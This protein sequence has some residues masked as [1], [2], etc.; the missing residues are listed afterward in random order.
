MILYIFDM[1]VV[2]KYIMK[3]ILIFNNCK[4]MMPDFK[5]V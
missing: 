3:N 1:I 5:V 2:N 4:A